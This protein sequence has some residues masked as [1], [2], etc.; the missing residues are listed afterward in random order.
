M[1]L[2]VHSRAVDHGVPVKVKAVQDQ[3][4]FKILT[5]ALAEHV[6]QARLPE[7]SSVPENEAW[8]RFPPEWTRLFADE[9][10]LT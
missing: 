7:T 5:L 6:L 8:L 3:G 4:S 1:Y 10:L 9:R 2:E